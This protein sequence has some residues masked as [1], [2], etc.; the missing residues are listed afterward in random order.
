[1]KGQFERCPVR[2]LPDGKVLKVFPFHI[3]LE[4]LE[5]RVLCRDDED[6]DAFVK[7]ICVCCLRKNVILV[8]YAV[9]SNHVHCVILA[10]SQGEAD[11]CAN[12]IKRMLAMYHRGKYGESSVMAGVDVKAIWLMSDRHVRNAL[13]Y[14]VRNAMDNGADCIQN[15]RWTG[16]RGMFCNGQS[17]GVTKVSELSKRDRRRIMHTDDDLS[18][19]TWMLNKDGELEPATVCDW[20]Y[21]ED[22]FLK[23]QA[24]FL[25]LIGSVNVPEM[26]QSLVLAPRIKRNDQ[27]FLLSV[28]ELS[29]RL[30]NTN[31]DGLPMSRKSRLLQIV[32]NSFKTDI[33]QLARVFQLSRDEVRL[34]LGEKRKY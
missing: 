17:A 5:D 18:A 23:D 3:S 7:I 15:Y 34:L 6:Y 12:E 14:D 30:F 21:L 29:Q 28:N 26:T 11:G 33:A 2:R 27:Q 22:A 10:E 31:V 24:Y 32:R 13:A 1:M 20:R 25:R 4:G 16:Y 19:V 9:V 8:I